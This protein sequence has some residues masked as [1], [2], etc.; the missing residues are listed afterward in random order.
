MPFRRVWQLVEGAIG[1]GIGQNK[2]T[3]L[4]KWKGGGRVGEKE[5]FGEQLTDDGDGV[6]GRAGIG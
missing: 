1:A 2:L 5:K 3:S 4:Q 6:V